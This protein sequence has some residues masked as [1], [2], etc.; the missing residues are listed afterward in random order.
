M[1]MRPWFVAAATALVAASPRVARGEP[2]PASPAVAVPVTGSPAPTSAQPMDAEPSSEKRPLPDYDGRGPRPTTPGEVAL[3]VPS[4]VLSPVYFT[5]E[6]LIRRPLGAA[7]SAAERA[8]LP[9]ILYNF[10]TFGV[11]HKAGIVARGVRRLRIQPER[12]RLRVL[13]RR[14]L[15][16]QRPACPRLVLDGRLDRRRRSSERVRF[17]GKD[18]LPTEA[19]TA[20]GAPTTS[21]IGL[22]PSSLQSAQS[23]YGEDTLDGGAL[24]DFPLW[25]ASTIEAALGVRSAL[26]PRRALRQRPGI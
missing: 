17:S 25:R 3:W 1:K 24:V 4:V 8:D 5:T 15:Q 22:G 21:S 7:I 11:E 26:V 10:F 16:R 20:S 19:R 9:T 12:R 2:S 23:R 6:W 18:T 13:G 14:V